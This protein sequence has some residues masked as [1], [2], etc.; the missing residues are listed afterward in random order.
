MKF[1][2]TLLAASRKNRSLLCVG[3]D[4]DPSLIPGVSPLS[5]NRA[6][7]DTTADLVCA[8]KPN[9]AFYEAM[10]IA[11]MKLLLKTVEYVPGHIPII[12]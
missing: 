12:G 3:L 10:G 4:P 8:Y 1:G 2:E 7:I 6:I 11:G 9:L 5:F